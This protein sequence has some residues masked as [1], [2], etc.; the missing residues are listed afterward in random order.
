MSPVNLHYRHCYT[1]LHRVKSSQLSAVNRE[2]LVNSSE[3][4]GRGGAVAPGA[5]DEGAQNSVTKHILTTI[6]VSLMKFGICAVCAESVVKHQLTN[7]ATPTPPA[8]HRAGSGVVRIDPLRFLAGCRTRRRRLN[9]A[10]SVPPS[11]L[12]LSLSLSLS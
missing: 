1:T 8:S 4:R 12:S 9:Q 7:T 10:L 11:S 2:H 5:A 6:K 3:T